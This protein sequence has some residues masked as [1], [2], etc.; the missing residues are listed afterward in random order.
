VLKD[1]NKP[2]IFSMARLDR[3]KNLTGLVELYGR[4]PRL[5]EL[6]NLVVVCGDHGN[7]SKDKE[8]QAEFKKM[9]DLIEQYN[10][11]GHIRWIS[12]QMNRVRNAELYRYIC[13][14]KG[15]FVQV[16]TCCKTAYSCLLKN[17]LFSHASFL[18]SLLS[19]KPLGLL[20]SR[21]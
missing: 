18:C 15:A 13:D 19:M 2:I 1:R 17:Y 3:V 14:T 10:L 16:T 7:P 4:N 11:N 5:Q 20:S 21:P 6:V 12:A 9:F 8:E